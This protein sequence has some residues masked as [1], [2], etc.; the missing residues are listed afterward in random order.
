MRVKMPPRHH[1]Q[2]Q[3]LCPNPF[4]YHRTSPPKRKRLQTHNAQK[5]ICHRSCRHWRRRRRR[6][7]NTYALTRT[8]HFTHSEILSARVWVSVSVCVC[9]VEQH[10]FTAPC[11]PRIQ[12]TGG[13][14]FLRRCGATKCRARSFIHF[15]MRGRV[16]ERGF[17]P[18]SL[19]PFPSPQK[20]LNA[21]PLHTKRLPYASEHARTFQYMLYFLVYAIPRKT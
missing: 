3:W 9:V 10:K 17:Y 8:C 5:P 15:L 14:T 4:P 18:A 1:Q 13:T 12:H 16:R 19:P 7:S 20:N 6:N 21:H 2:Q 11:A